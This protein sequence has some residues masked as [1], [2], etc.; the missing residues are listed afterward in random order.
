[1]NTTIPMIV[2]VDTRVSMHAAKV[3]QQ[4]PSS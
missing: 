2:D 1:M 4:G 3:Q